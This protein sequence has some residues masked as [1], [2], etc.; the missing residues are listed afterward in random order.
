M[1]DCLLMLLLGVAA[2]L[3]GAYSAAFIDATSFKIIGL[4]FMIGGF[5]INTFSIL[6]IF[7]KIDEETRNRN[8]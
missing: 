7:D 1:K 2:A 3:S 8:K 6:L 4:M 5:V